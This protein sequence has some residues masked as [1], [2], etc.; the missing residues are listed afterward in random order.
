MKVHINIYNSSEG[1]AWSFF[2]LDHEVNSF[3]EFKQKIVET[4]EAAKD[5]GILHIANKENIGETYV[6]SSDPEIYVETS[7]SA[8]IKDEH[9][10]LM[11]CFVDKS[12]ISFPHHG[13]DFMYE[14]E[15][16]LGKLDFDPNE[17]GEE[18]FIEKI[19]NFYLSKS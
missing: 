12:E 11:S 2:K 3:A 19:F 5:N 13:S 1:D 6:L 16:K 7:L 18:K 10:N 9:F 17:Y 8:V 14:D 15:E 4:Y